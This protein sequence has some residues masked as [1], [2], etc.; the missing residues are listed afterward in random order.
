MRTLGKH[1]RGRLQ[2]SVLISPHELTFDAIDIYNKEN[3]QVEY[4]RNM[5]HDLSARRFEICLEEIKRSEDQNY[6]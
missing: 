1:A 5:C 2:E 3:S 4:I 6:Q